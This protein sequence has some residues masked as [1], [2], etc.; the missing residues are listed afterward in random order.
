MFATVSHFHPSLIFP[1][2]AEAYQSWAP[3]GLRFNGSLLALPTN[4]RLGWKWMEVANTL[5]F[6]DE[7]TITAIK[8]GLYSQHSIFSVTYKGVQ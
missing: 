8:Q 6:Y 3:T 2:K 7:A 4:I 5:A 1:G